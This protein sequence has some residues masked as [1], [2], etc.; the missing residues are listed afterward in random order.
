M[1]KLNCSK[2]LVISPHTDD[3]EIG[4]GGSISM[5]IEEGV[6]VYYAAFSYC[7]LSVLPEYPVD[8]LKSECK[9]A[10]NILGIDENKL[11]FLDFEVRSFPE[12]RQK[13]LDALIKIKNEIHPD[14]ILIPSSNDIHQDH[15]V[16]YSESLRAFKKESSIWGYEHPW[17]NLKFTTDVFVSLD[18]RHIDKKIFALKEYKSQNLRSYFDDKYLKSL[19]YTRGKQI[20]KKY[21]E[22]FELIRFIVN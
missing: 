14:L 16:I 1:V 4:A 15:Q 20:E 13:I 5:F 2:I 22:S 8:I 6:E 18:K 10:T 12:N 11:F 21:A 9:N 19:A 7:E 3:G 17:N